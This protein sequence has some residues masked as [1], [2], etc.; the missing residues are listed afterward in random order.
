[1]YEL[2]GKR[3]NDVFDTPGGRHSVFDHEDGTMG[4]P[5]SVERGHA[6]PLRRA[7]DHGL[8]QA[9]PRDEAA[10]A[11]RGEAARARPRAWA[12]RTTSRASRRWRPSS[13]R[14]SWGTRSWASISLQNLDREHA[15]D[16]RDVSLLTTLAASLSVALRTARLIDETQKRVAE[17]ATIN[18][19][20]EA[21]T[22][23]LELAP[24]LTIVGEKLQRSVRCRHRL[25]RAPGRG[26]EPSSTS[27]TTSRL[28]RTNRRSRCA[29]GRD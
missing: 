20:G 27:P 2:V 13:C 15:F 24:L 28:A 11:D 16:D 29:L 17:L 8:P 26:A 10:A 6:L 14:C 22:T 25:H 19:V 1:M 9:R 4:F 3:A 23:E 12:S 21:L 7:A 5:Y 18:S